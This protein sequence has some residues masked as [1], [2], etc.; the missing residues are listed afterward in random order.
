MKSE[1]RHFAY[2]PL[3]GGT[4]VPATKTINDLG[5]VAMP[6]YK[7]TYREY[8]PVA[9]Q[10]FF[11]NGDTIVAFVRKNTC[12]NFQMRDFSLE[13]DEI[14]DMALSYHSSKFNNNGGLMFTR[15]E[16][17]RLV[18]AM[19]VEDELHIVIPDNG[20]DLDNEDEEE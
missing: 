9:E 1:K 10:S 16:L 12:S 15:D 13:L 6:Y 8:N 18:N 11:G 2:S 20:Y 14:G 5:E 7:G 17:Q 4:S 19:D 3:Y